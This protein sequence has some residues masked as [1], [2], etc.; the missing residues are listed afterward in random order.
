MHLDE[1]QVQR[2]LHGE[3][4]TADALAVRRHLAE[5]GTCR[6]RVDV[7]T[8]E[9][10]DVLTALAALDHA[11]PAVSS[12]AIERR[13]RATAVRRVPR[14]AGIVI[15][16]GIA[17]AAYAAPG[18]P[19]PAWLGALSGWVRGEPSVS[20]VTS[21]PSP[22]IPS[23]AAGIAVRP[24]ASLTIAFT[25]WQTAGVARVRLADGGHVEVR[26]PN[27]AATF[28]SDADRL[29][30]DNRGG[31]ATFEIQIPRS[32]PRVEILVNGTRRYLKEG[33]RVAANES[34]EETG[35]HTIP[36]SR[37]P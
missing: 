10:G 6:E 12:G 34:S 1:G 37:A 35:V 17:G 32:A 24:G 14:A 29:V 21:S 27:G 4:T 26:A 31:A 15:A 16:L 28:S 3:L 19:L 22:L 20:Q 5:C 33:D 2:L 7:A 11:V 36:M 23:D 18:S 13:A 25:S 30:I 9:E 8:D